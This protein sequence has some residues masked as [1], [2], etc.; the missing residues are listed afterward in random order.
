MEGGRPPGASIQAQGLVVETQ[1]AA[2]WAL[3]AQPLSGC[4]CPFWEVEV[5][6]TASEMRDR[7]CAQQGW[8]A[9]D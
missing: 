6:L 7:L 5:V 9:G 4:P 1:G 3:H 2:L 8:S